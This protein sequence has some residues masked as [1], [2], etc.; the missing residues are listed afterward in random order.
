MVS[1]QTVHTWHNVTSNDWAV[2]QLADSYE[3]DFSFVNAQLVPVTSFAVGLVAPYQYG[4][5]LG[6]TSD[7]NMLYSLTCVQQNNQTSQSPKI[8]FVVGANGPADPNIVVINYYGAIGK[9]NTVP[10]VGENF[11]LTFSLSRQI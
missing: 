8:A 4:L 1:G 3:T 7:F 11:Y 9:F 6:P 5:L 2:C 10:G